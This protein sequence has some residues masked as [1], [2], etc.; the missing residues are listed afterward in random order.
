MDLSS[1]L[2]LCC[3][4]CF[5]FVF[6]LFHFECDTLCLFVGFFNDSPEKS[7]R[8]TLIYCKELCSLVNIVP[9]G[10]KWCCF[11]DWLQ[12]QTYRK[13]TKCINLADSSDIRVPVGLW[14]F[15]A[16]SGVTGYWAAKGGPWWLICDVCGWRCSHPHWN[17][18]SQCSCGWLLSYLFHPLFLCII[19]MIQ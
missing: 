13:H 6:V 11:M 18:H 1:K 10:I 14:W 3:L 15:F 8:S 16:W 2:V 19:I 7:M 17:P 12:C 4:I 9:I 5:V